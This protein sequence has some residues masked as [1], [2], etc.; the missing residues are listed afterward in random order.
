MRLTRIEIENFKGIG[1]RQVIELRPIT[2]LFGPN[3]AGKSTILQAL[4]YVREILERQNP[5]PDQ[6]IAGG[7]IDLGG[8]SALVHNHEL[9]RAISIKLVI[10]IGDEQGSDRLPINGGG[11]LKHPDFE[12][13]RLRY[14]VGEN[15]ELEDYA[16]VQEIGIGID[17][18]WSELIAG[19]Y[20][21]AVRI[22]TDGQPVAAIHS[23][24]QAGRAYITA[25]NF[26]HP[27][28]QSIDESDESLIEEDAEALA[29]EPSDDEIGADPFASPLGGEIWELSRDMASDG[30]SELGSDFRVSIATE[31]GALPDL[32]RPLHCELRDPEVGKFELEGNTPRVRGLAA[33]LDELMLGPVR[34]ARDFLST[35]TY[36]GPLREIPTRGF[37]PRLS[38]DESR[39]AQGL[40][41]WDLL[42]TDTRGEL[43]DAVNNW[44]SSESKLAT[45]YRLE[46]ALFREIPIPSRIS[47]LFERGLTEDDIGELQELYED[48]DSRTQIALLDFA[49]GILVAPS[50]VGV[51][52][53][54]MIPVIVGCLSGRIGLLAVEQPE[55]HIHP[56]IQVAMG[57]LLI[58][59]VHD[60]EGEPSSR[61]SLLIETH[62]EHIML[63][64][65]RRIRE[66]SEAE[67]PPGAPSLTTDAL[68][69]I[70][71]ESDDG[72]VKFIPLRVASD[73]DFLDRWPR[74]F[75]EERSEELF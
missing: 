65:L 75:F 66:T 63:R 7:L 64:L 23:P 46:K 60:G 36:I 20:V 30:S 8:F 43:F 13:L 72:S 47:A 74:G 34:I 4:H 3:S 45:N 14:V 44:L 35:M 53:S 40:A 18:K 25:F 58:D 22:D 54:Q 10:N 37:R 27:L 49:K 38:P 73:G 70:Y 51:G 21:S 33:L 17:V 12:N 61:K 31:V 59:A 32:N 67:L 2:L 69:V 71:A 26:A 68:S 16:V 19:P 29:L 6:T 9:D 62:S 39:W 41:A 42:Y 1:K 24:P 11:Y 48:L 57:D 55:L 52:I 50:D 15:T 56:A 5:D 28:L